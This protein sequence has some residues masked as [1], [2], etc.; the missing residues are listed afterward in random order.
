[1]RTVN[2]CPKK[3]TMHNTCDI[4]YKPHSYSCDCL[5]CRVYSVISM[6]ERMRAEQCCLPTHLSCGIE[7][8]GLKL[9]KKLEELN[10]CTAM[11]Q[12]CSRHV[13]KNNRNLDRK[14]LLY[15]TGKFLASLLVKISANIILVSGKAFIIRSETP[16]SAHLMENA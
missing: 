4:K 10:Q 12:K 7:L 5:K 14:A 2:L 16:S 9:T 8:I 15:N 13:K 11:Q 3:H 1:M 6:I